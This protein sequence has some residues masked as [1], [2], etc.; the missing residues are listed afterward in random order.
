[1]SKD[2]DV[3]EGSAGPRAPSTPRNRSTAPPT[4]GSARRN[5]LSDLAESLRKMAEH[6]RAEMA[7]MHNEELALRREMGKEREQGETTRTRM[8]ADALALVAR[9]NGASGSGA[10]QGG[11]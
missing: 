10:G 8:L 5:G 7:R 9:L 6:D 11:Q 1:M 2:F 3:R 4:P